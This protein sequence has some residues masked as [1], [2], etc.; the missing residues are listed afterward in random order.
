MMTKNAQETHKLL[1]NLTTH[2]INWSHFLSI[3]GQHGYI[4]I[5]DK[6]IYTLALWE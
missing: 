2:H 1:Y 5:L 6:K 4:L 3:F